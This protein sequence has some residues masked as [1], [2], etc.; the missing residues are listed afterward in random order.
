MRLRKQPAAQI[1]QSPDGRRPRG[2]IILDRMISIPLLVVGLIAVVIGALLRPL[3]GR[4]VDA[5]NI[6]ELRRHYGL[7]D[8]TAEDLYRL[9]RREGFGSAWATLEASR[10]T[11]ARRQ[12]DE[13]RVT[14]RSAERRQATDRRLAGRNRA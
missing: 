8:A 12:V 2:A 4:W 11:N 3:V 13:R 10:R 1:R 9:A 6:A 5:R 7:D 14:K